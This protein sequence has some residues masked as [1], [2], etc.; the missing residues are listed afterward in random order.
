MADAVSPREFKMSGQKRR[1]CAKSGKRFLTDPRARPEIGLK[2]AKNTL[3]HR[4]CSPRNDVRREYF[5][6][7]RVRLIGETE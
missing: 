6:R 4:A 5:G 3:W 2:S 1:V 7:S